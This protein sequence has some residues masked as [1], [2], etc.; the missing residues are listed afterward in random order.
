[1]TRGV[2]ASIDRA[3]GFDEALLYS[4]LHEPIYCQG[5]GPHWSAER[6]MAEYPEFNLDKEDDSPIY[7]TGEMIYPW[8]FED[9]SE[10]RKLEDVANRVAKDDD[11]PD[12]YDEE[13]LA[14][15]EVPVYAASYVDDMFV[16]HDLAT[17][18]ASK[19]RGCKVFSTNVMYHD[20]VRS[21]M[22]EVVRQVFAL[23]D[24]VLD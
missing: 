16:D 20:A 21:R 13:Q 1:M 9:F 17:E 6:V 8:M 10:L 12:L 5:K 22:D 23:R 11:W 7:F 18:T 19:I 24:D 2:L 14:L 15:N 3:Q 4:I